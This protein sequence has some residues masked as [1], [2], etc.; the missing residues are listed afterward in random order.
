[1]RKKSVK[2]RFGGTKWAVVVYNLSTLFTAKRQHRAQ[3]FMWLL[4]VTSK[5]EKP[6]QD[7]IPDWR[8]NCMSSIVS[9]SPSECLC[10]IWNC[11]LG[12]KTTV[13][14]FVSASG[15]TIL[16]LF[17]PFKRVNRFTDR[18]LVTQVEVVWLLPLLLLHAPPP[19]SCPAAFLRLLLHL[20]LLPPALGTDTCRVWVGDDTSAHAGHDTTTTT[21]TT[22]TATTTTT[23]T[24][25]TTNN[26]NNNNI[27]WVTWHI[28]WNLFLNWLDLSQMSVKGGALL[29]SYWSVCR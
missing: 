20:H 11:V 21:A 8:T 24:T 5:G 13:K 25:T 9:K 29:A 28:W 18:H 22:T 19:P 10:V 7:E 12:A 6:D 4:I 27:M 3:L 1:M 17:E 16:R 15:W 23:T 26:N 14:M 2:I